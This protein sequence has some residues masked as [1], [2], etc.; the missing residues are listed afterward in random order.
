M[1]DAPTQE[2]RAGAGD[3]D[4]TTDT[5]GI[6]DSGA[7]ADHKPLSH[8]TAATLDFLQQWCP[9]GPWVLCAIVPDGDR[10]TTQTFTDLAKAG[11]WIDARQGHQNLYFTVNPV[12]HPVSSKP[13][14][15]DMRG[16]RA[17][18]VDVDPRAGEPLEQERE[19]SLR[20]LREFS[21]PPTVIID[22]GGG[23]QA[24]W[25]LEEELPTAGSEDRA[26]E[27]E[28]Y[29]IQLEVLLQADACHNIDRLMRLPG[30]VNVPGEKKRRKRRTEAL[31]GVVEADWSRRYPIS[32]FIPAPRV[33]SADGGNGV[34]V[35]LSGNL[36]KLD[37]LDEL[38][39]SVT[40]RTKMLIVNGD[41]PDD[42]TRY[43]SRSEVL[44]AVLCELVRAGVS[45]DMMAAIILDGDYGIAQHVLEQPRPQQYAA[46]QIKRARE[47]A[48][49]P[50]LRKLNDKHAVLGNQNNKCRVMER[51]R[52]PTGIAGQEREV[53]SLQSFADFQ[54]RYLNK[55]VVVGT[56][57]EGRDI[58]MAAGK[59]WLEHPNRRQFHS[60]SFSPRDGE[61]IEAPSGD[62][63]DR[64]LNLWRGYAVQPLPGDWT[65]MR[66]HIRKVIAEGNETS[67]D[68]IIKWMAWTV[69]NPDRPAEVAIVLRGKMGTGK[70]VFGK[71]M[72]RLFG[73]HGLHTGGTELLTGRFN[74]HLADCCVLF[75]DEI[76]W[77][78]DKKAEAR[79][80]VY[81][82]EETIVI[83]PKGV[84]AAA[85]PNM[86]HVIISSNEDWI[87]P[88]GP[89]ERR[90]AVFD[91]S[92][93]HMQDG[94]YFKAL[95]RQMDN[96]G[97][98]AMLHDLRSM[99]LG[100]WHPRDD[101]PDTEALADQKVRGL[102]PV[103]AQV[104]EM[105][106]EGALP[107]GVRSDRRGTDARPF[108]AT[109]DLRKI[110]A[111]RS[112]AKVSSRSANNALKK[113]GA[114]EN[115]KGRPRGF[116]LPLLNEARATWNADPSLPTRVWDD[117]PDWISDT[118]DWVQGGPK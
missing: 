30:T 88:A 9:G 26:A 63:D 12:L 7:G 112:R 42:P 69:Q 38:P 75:A 105:L 21:P 2:D 24:F 28:A 56:N 67:A 103:H 64:Q 68:Y 15:T 40:P 11:A 59:W 109:E 116:I 46:R 80:K 114:E 45:D 5:G 20:L 16:M 74:Q 49:D 107:D 17:L 104:L 39:Q 92:D 36:P 65:L 4:R 101:R 31:A 97:L 25:M 98:A 81:L 51:V 48:I 85:W 82:T 87:V 23:H 72:V 54:N 55:R 33:Q 93:E 111:E 10:A 91:V 32:A 1:K 60:L 95:Y 84:D 106:D 71:M 76:V 115:T 117:T 57:K 83:E 99:A 37:S 19:R 79:I 62:P 70:G 110:A 58:T 47:E 52:R 41:D 8:D 118:P 90:Y 94:A 50:W 29:N 53:V 113:I 34:E 86:L 3:G 27:V 102:D 77:D 18:H 89:H 61:V 22:S 6:P 73:Q 66:D 13:Y 35:R 100:D 108:V 14:K 43:P 78:G 44:F 96:G